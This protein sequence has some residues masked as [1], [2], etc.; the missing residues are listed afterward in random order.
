MVSVGIINVGGN[1]NNFINILSELNFVKTELIND[2][3][4]LQ[5]KDLIIFPG[6]NDFGETI[7]MLKKKDLLCSLVNHLKNKPYI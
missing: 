7:R 4:S 5:K 1:I 6:V 2:K 3:F